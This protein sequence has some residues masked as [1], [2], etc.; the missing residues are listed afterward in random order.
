MT[1]RV[2]SLT[3]VLD[4]DIRDD[5][6]QGLVD[7][8]LHMKNVCSIGLRITDSRDYVAQS[9]AREK[10]GREILKVLYPVVEETS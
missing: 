9:R 7:A 8:I 3:V 10:L 2:N 1:D 4:K 6:V 5:D